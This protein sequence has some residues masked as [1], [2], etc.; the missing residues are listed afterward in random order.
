MFVLKKWQKFLAKTLIAFLLLAN[1]GLVAAVHAA[2]G[3][4]ITVDKDTTE[5]DAQEQTVTLAVEKGDKSETTASTANTSEYDKNLTEKE[6]A[7][8][9]SNNLLA[10]FL[11][12]GKQ[13]GPQWLKTS[14]FSFQ[15]NENNKPLYCFETIQPFGE[16]DKNGAL[17]FW[18]GRY[19]NASDSGGTA[20]V[21]FGWRK[22]S[23]DKKS[24]VGFNTFYDH[25]F[26]Y[27][28]ARVGL[29]AEYFNKQAEYRFNWYHP[30]SGDRLTGTSYLDS[31]IL[32][33]YIRAV[34]GF[35]FELGTA[36]HGA[37][38]W[39]LYAGG[40]YWDNKYN[41]DEKGVSLRSSMQLTPRV[42]LEVSYLHSNT[43]GGDLAGKIMYNMADTLGSAF[44]GDLASRVDGEDITGVS[45]QIYEDGKPVGAPIILDKA[46]LNAH[47]TVKATYL[48][49]SGQPVQP[50]HLQSDDL[51][52]KLLQKV[53]RQNDIKTETF[54]K[55]VAYT[56][57]ISVT[58]TNTSGTALS[59]VTLQAY[60]NDS[61]VGST[62]TTDSS[63]VGVISDLAV[64][65]YTVKATY[66]STTAESSSVTV[67]KD[68]TMSTTISLEVSGGDVTV[69]VMDASGT[70]LSGASVSITTS[71][72]IAEAEKSLFDTIL[73]VKMAYAATTGYS[74]NA[75][76]SATGTAGFSNL[77]AGSY[78]FTV[79]YGGQTMTSSSVT[80]TAST[81][82]TAYVVVATSGTGSAAIKVTDGTNVLSGATVS[83]TVSGV[84]QTATTD[85][86]GVAVLSDLPTGTQTFTATKSD[87]PTCTAG[88]TIASGVTATATIPLV[89]QIGNAAITVADTDG[90]ALSGATVSVTVN[91]T[92]QAVQTGSTGVATFTGLAVGTYD[93]T[94]TLDTYV[95]KTVSVII[96]G[97]TTTPVTVPLARQSGS[98]TITVTDTNSVKLAGAT[99]NLTVG[100]A[101]QTA[102]TDSTGMATFTGIATG[103]YSFTATKT[104]YVT[105]SGS[106]TVSASTGGSATVAL[107][108]SVGKVLITVMNA[109]GTVIPSAT[110][111][112]TVGSATQTA[113][114]D[115]TGVGTFTGIA[116]GTYYFTASATGY[117]TSGGSDSVT[118]TSSGGSAS[119]S[120][121]ATSYTI[122]SSAST[123]GTIS[124]SGSTTC[125]SEGS[126]SYTIAYSGDYFF[127]G[128]V[129]NGDT[130]AATTT[131]YDGCNKTISQPTANTSVYAIFTSLPTVTFI[132]YTN[133]YLR[134]IDTTTGA[135]VVNSLYNMCT[136]KFTA[137]PG[138]IFSIYYLSGTPVGITF[139]IPSVD[140]TYIITNDDTPTFYLN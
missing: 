140:A 66:F 107:T 110:V 52:A 51:T 32:Y 92:A 126:V 100:S 117:V 20:N 5:K 57:N 111:N 132:N 78:T 12:N 14:D 64:G 104:D 77:P 54:K 30:V 2:D 23:E 96:A 79:T 42:S 33:S 120:L 119:V 47:Y 35:D 25:G 8:K 39:K 17:W 102:T 38:W 36:L 125:T 128:I 6:K 55:F 59:G 123:G 41:A 109:S 133:F 71:T 13:S 53:E 138:H 60:Q 99:V 73:G 89:N 95:S 116:T 19:A 106:V 3:T 129:V 67:T 76:T 134:I 136:T 135:T 103:T 88:V 21:G 24:L 87:Y 26:Q 97:G 80:V 108:S 105:N 18:Q 98:V 75:T 115:S 69:T 101:T 10:Y 49:K 37:P 28:L 93:F 90:N 122:Y 40:Y 56:G 29:G 62:V 131:E 70:P 127:S 74:I 22:L 137:R 130:T 65:A 94:V 44:W 50:K 82:S 11:S 9:F 121:T 112:L 84:T 31:G 113:T 7:L 61:A 16:V 15:L 45:L 27:N 118:V 43:N 91:G 72:T 85:S 68:Q 63:G 1:P 83:V 86:Y 139:T 114:T 46:K 4:T 58:V 124:P 81:T 48:D 34:E